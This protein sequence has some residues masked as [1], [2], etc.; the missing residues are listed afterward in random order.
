MQVPILKELA[1]AGVIDYLLARRAPGGY[2]LVADIRGAKR[3]LTA[4]RGHP[5]VFRHLDAV[6]T[7]VTGLGITEFH[8]NESTGSESSDESTSP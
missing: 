1:A 2:E 8:V 7:F 3:V 6:A 5:R 4:Q